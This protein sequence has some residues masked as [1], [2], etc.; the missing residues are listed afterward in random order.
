[1]ADG[2]ITPIRRDPPYT[3]TAALNDIHLLLTVT[4]PGHSTLPEIA[5]IL[6]RTG[7][8]LIAA[9]D[10]EASTTETALG[11]PVACVD[12]GDTS[13]FVRQAPAGAGLVIEI[14]TRTDAERAALAVTLD[15]QPLHPAELSTVPPPTWSPAARRGPF[16]CPCRALTAPSTT[17]SN[18]PH[19]YLRR[20]YARPSSRAGSV[21]ARD[22]AG[23]R[24]RA[25]QR[26]ARCGTGRTGPRAGTG[27][28]TGD[29][30]GREA[31][32]RAMSAATWTCPASSSNRSGPTAS[33]WRCGSPRTGTVTASSTAA[34]AWRLR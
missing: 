11:W 19:E 12:A 28:A 16:P 3:D 21:R 4:D 26:A 34:A 15:G 33:W 27:S 10:I 29:D 8:P 17:G 23:A 31:G 25:R 22:R 6:A 1:M 18:Q 7:P 32:H 5:E 13:V 2:S 20:C 14:C 24:Y 9:R 30:P